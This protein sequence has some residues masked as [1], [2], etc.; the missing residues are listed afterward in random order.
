MICYSLQMWEMLL[1]TDVVL[2]PAVA[3]E[4]APD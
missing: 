1:Q 4:E 3:G 2:S